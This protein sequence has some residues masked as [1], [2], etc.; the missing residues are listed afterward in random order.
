MNDNITD[1]AG[2]TYPYLEEYLA[3]GH[4]ALIFTSCYFFAILSDL[5]ILD[6]I[7]R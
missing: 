5:K 1:A 6:F 4:R 7:R 2:V 3:F